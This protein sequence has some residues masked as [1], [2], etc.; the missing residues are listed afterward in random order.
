MSENNGTGDNL[1]ESGPKT[2]WALNMSVNIWE[3]TNDLSP[4][5]YCPEG[6]NS[7]NVC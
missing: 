4:H 3:R 7:T 1:V 5:I 2:F 6:D